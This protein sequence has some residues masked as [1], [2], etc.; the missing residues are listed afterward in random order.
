MAVNVNVGGRTSPTSNFEEKN[1]LLHPYAI[2]NG[3]G[4]FA[5]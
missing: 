1:D 3:L 4:H 2:Q 5:R